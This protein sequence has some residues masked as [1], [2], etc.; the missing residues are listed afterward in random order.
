MVAALG[1]T[2]AG[3]ALPRLRDQMLASSE[4][5]ALLKD[6]P[7]V[8]TS[9]VD[10]VALSKM[11]VGTWGHTYVTWLDRCGVTPDTREPVHYIDDPELAYVMTRY[12]ECH[13][14]YH[15]V[16]GLSVS[17]PSELALKVFELANFGLPSTALSAL[18]GLS[19]FFPALPS[20]TTLAYKLSRPIRFLNPYDKPPSEPKRPLGRLTSHQ[21]DRFVRE[22][23]PWAFR[24]GASARPL[25][26]VYW[27]KRWDQP[28]DDLKRELGIWVSLF[29]MTILRL[30]F[31]IP[32]SGYA[33]PQPMQQVNPKILTTVSRKRCCT[34][35]LTWTL[36]PTSLRCGMP[37]SG[38]RLPTV[39]P[40]L[41]ECIDA[42]F[43]YQLTSYFDKPYHNH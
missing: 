9:T 10:M 43:I 33:G 32:V 41:L 38:T 37:L 6:R 2:T 39:R 12:R 28:I 21:R 35:E 26:T 11:P 29:Q 42:T 1:E 22:F 8:N 7:R 23:A 14:F 5:R 3:S 27:E 34:Y 30:Y 31:S 19:A 15:A 36:P 25:I 40:S 13:D 20:P 16:C 24:C 17:V 4:G 18:S